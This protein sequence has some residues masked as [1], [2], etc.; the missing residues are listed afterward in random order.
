M[1]AKCLPGGEG[2]TNELKGLL[3]EEFQKIGN[4]W[5]ENDEMYALE[6]A[7]ESAKDF[8]EKIANGIEGKLGKEAADK[9]RKE[10]EM[11]YDEE[12][13]AFCDD[14]YKGSA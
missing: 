5:R 7:W 13:K 1:T 14:Y 11:S 2:M 6:K 9:F 8:G 3:I 4:L 10:M 12:Y